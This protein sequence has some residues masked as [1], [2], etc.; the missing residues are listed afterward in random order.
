MKKWIWRI[1]IIACVGVMVFTGYRI[2]K[3]LKEYSAAEQETY[4]IE[5]TQ[6]D[7]FAAY[8]TYVTGRS[9]IQTRVTVTDADTIVT[10]STCDYKFENARMVVHA[11][12]VKV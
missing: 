11:K 6:Q 9:E 5:Y 8:L 2:N 4:R 3:Q 12:M 1:A 7:G 10:L